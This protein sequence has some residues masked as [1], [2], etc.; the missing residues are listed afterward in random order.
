MDSESASKKTLAFK[1]SCNSM[2]WKSKK[3]LKKKFKIGHFRTRAGIWIY[4]VKGVLVQ[5]FSFSKFFKK[6]SKVF[7]FFQQKKSKFPH[8]KGCKFNPGNPGP[9]NRDRDSGSGLALVGI[10][11][12]GIKNPGNPENPG[13]LG[14]GS[15]PGFGIFQKCKISPKNLKFLVF[16]LF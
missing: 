2:R 9:K 16:C 3:K 15:R 12:F 13:F 8:S 10:G 14:P 5:K 1:I 11:I 4:L 6:L 7:P